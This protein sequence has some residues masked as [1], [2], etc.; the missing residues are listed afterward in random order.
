L[1]NNSI[2]NLSF[3]W[4]E[5]N[6]LVLDRIHNKSLTRLYQTSSDVVNGSYSYYKSI[7]VKK[8]KYTVLYSHA[9]TVNNANFIA[10]QNK[11]IL[12]EKRQLS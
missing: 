1:S 8:L 11:R 12:R 10:E 7:P 4:S 6:G 9:V 3:E 2:Q 5:H